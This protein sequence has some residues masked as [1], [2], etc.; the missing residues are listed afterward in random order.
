MGGDRSALVARCVGRRT[1]VSAVPTQDRLNR[2]IRLDPHQELD[3]DTYTPPVAG[4]LH[5]ALRQELLRL[6]HHEEDL[7][8]SEAARVH[9][10]ESMPVTVAIHRKCAAEL[11]AAA[12]GLL[13]PSHP[14]PGDR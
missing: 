11:R 5:E 4:Q 14:Q 10:W 8:A 9:Y 12:D 7:A 13:A 2:T 3:M 1:D 6:A